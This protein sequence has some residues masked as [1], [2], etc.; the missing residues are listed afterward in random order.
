MKPIL[1]TPRSLLKIP[2]L[3]ISPQLGR[4]LD[5][6]ALFRA[7]MEIKELSSPTFRKDMSPSF[8]ANA[9]VN[10]SGVND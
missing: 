2:L 10:V 3:D 7:T 9:K 1:T 4:D 8:I 6:L 5:N